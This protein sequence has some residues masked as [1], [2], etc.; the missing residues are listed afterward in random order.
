[1]EEIYGKGYDFTRSRYEREDKTLVRTCTRG[2]A[3]GFKGGALVWGSEVAKE[4]LN[5][6]VRGHC[7]GGGTLG[8]K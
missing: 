1:M 3:I 4:K 5:G 6:D 8:L 2:G 7:Y